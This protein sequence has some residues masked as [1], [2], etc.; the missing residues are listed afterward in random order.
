MKLVK[1]IFK[2]IKENYVADIRKKHQSKRNLIFKV[3]YG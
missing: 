1:K 2:K 3:I